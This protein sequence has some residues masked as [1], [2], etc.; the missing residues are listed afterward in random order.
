MS[1]SH[2]WY[3]Y[4]PG[5][6]SAIMTHMATTTQLQTMDRDRAWFEDDLRARLLRYA[7]IHTTSDRHGTQT[8][9]TPGQFD[10]A[11]LLGDELL[12]MGLA[13]V[14]IDEHCYLI[15][16]IP[17]TVDSG[18]PFGLIAHLDTSPDSSGEGVNP[19]VHERYDGGTIS[20][21]PGHTLEPESSPQLR[22]YVGDTIITTDGTTLLGA[23]DKA[24]IA[25]I[26][27]AIY[28]LIEHPELPRPP[29][30]VIFTPD[31][32]IGH[33]MALLSSDALSSG[34]C[35]TV[36]GT[37]EG[38]IEAEC[39]TAYKALVHFTGRV[40]HPGQARGKLA[41]AVTMAGVFLAGLPRSESPEATD[42]R[43]GFYCPVEVQASMGSATVE[44]IIRDFEAAEVERRLEFLRS[45]AASV[46][47]SF[48]GG[49]VNVVTE[50]QYLNMRRAFD[51]HPE[52]IVRLQDAIRATGIEPFMESI[53]GGTD[54]A[55]LTERG[56]PT[57]NLFVGGH[58]LHGRYE[59]IALSAMVRAAKTL[60][61]LAQGCAVP[62]EKART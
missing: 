8:P 49:A 5:T 40:V 35:Y 33:G 27:T 48:P 17:G 28:F 16:R 29:I 59:W 38:G 60:V 25:E 61:N 37:D 31:E 2:R 50:Q 57:P 41:N 53:R 58:N 24:G 32:E 13:D 54:G 12:A 52:V 10:L 11:R 30:E 44:L 15:A 7:R 39:F 45:L 4:A 34:F 1:S 46:A 36:D 55:R 43:Y 20:L 42:G 21:G 47:G 3:S 51:Q 26:M 19:Q 14:S 62:G 56:V 18:Q 23:D 22:S 6:V 9:S